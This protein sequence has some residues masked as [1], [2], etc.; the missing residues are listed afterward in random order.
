M[1]KIEKL[2]DYMLVEEEV[3]RIGTEEQI[4]KMVEEMGYPVW[5]KTLATY[6]IVEDYI[7]CGGEIKEDV[8]LE[9]KDGYIYVDSDT[10]EL[11]F[12]PREDVCPQMLQGILETYV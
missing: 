12:Y 8:F 7:C 1:M 9:V 5:I 2:Y 4:E 3:F 6:T 10:S 11:D